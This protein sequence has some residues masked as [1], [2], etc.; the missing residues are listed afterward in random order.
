MAKRKPKIQHQREIQHIGIYGRVSTEEQ[1]REGF[2]LE[3]QKTRCKAMAEVKGWPQPTHY[4]DEGIS[5]TKDASKRPQLAR[6]MADVRSGKLDAIIILSL[7]RLG[8]KTRLVLDLVDELGKYGVTL[9]SCKE[10]LDTSTPQGQFVLTLFAALAQLERDLIAERTSAALAERGAIDGEKGGRLPY[11]YQ[12]S[13]SGIVINPAQANVVER[14]FSLR[15]EG[16]SFAKIA[17]HLNAEQIPSP[18]DSTWHP[19]SIREVLFNQPA[20]LGGQRGNSPLHW[21]KLLS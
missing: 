6:L 4:I 5:G 9:V 16:R 21:P 13:P 17:N 19:T 8:R 1:A 20:Y 10:S 11:G 14:I 18:R 3:A 2:G 15:N 7:D 12:R